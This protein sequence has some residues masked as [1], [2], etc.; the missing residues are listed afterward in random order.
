ME[1]EL[2][3]GGAKAIIDP[4]G[5][6]LTN[7]SDDFGDVLFPKRSLKT[8]D[9]Q[10]KA[11]GGSHVCLPNFGLGG[12]SGQPQHGFGRTVDWEVSDKTESSVLLTLREGEGDYAAMSSLLTYQLS[13]QN[14]LMTLEVTNNGSENLR[15]A[16]A[17]HPYF[18]ALGDAEVKI[19]GENYPLDELAETV[20]ISGNAQ[21][22]Q[23]QNR[24]VNL[25]SDTL[26]TWALW[27]DQLGEYVCVE[28]TLGGNLFVEPTPQEDE[29]LHP[30]ET[31]TYAASIA[32]RQNTG[33][34]VENSAKL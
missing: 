26:T 23:T 11:R 21:E 14:L 5:A 20:F 4:R 22:L 2:W 27:T 8:A 17:F 7:L 31:K 24:V 29:I 34:P 30:G 32:W 12:D 6:W 13:E 3:N 9:G 10:A 33:R 25:A 18:A 19:S 28:P 16:P 1:I 15:V